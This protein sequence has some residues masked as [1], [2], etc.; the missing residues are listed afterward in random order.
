MGNLVG[1]V[2]DSGP[3]GTDLSFAEFFDGHHAQLF[4]TLCLMAGSYAEAEDLMQDA[5]LRLW[6]RWD[7][8]GSISDP[9]SYLY[10]TA[11]NLYRSRLRRITRAARRV[12]TPAPGPDAFEAVETR[13]RLARGL[14][15]LS[16]RQR[17]AIVLTDLMGYSS[18]EAGRQ[19][20]IKAVTVR[21][22]SSQARA[23]LRDSM[24][25]VDE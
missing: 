18:E 6:E 22:L 16:A 12:L 4:G 5:F 11:F 21:V 20:G 8:V 10:R 9:T 1:T 24:E 25:D 17:A 2:T 19:L 3:A 13:D 23:S 15:R 14:R 7:R